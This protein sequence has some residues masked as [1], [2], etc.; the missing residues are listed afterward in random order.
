MLIVVKCKIA[1]TH[2][3]PAQLTLTFLGQINIHKFMCM[4]LILSKFITKTN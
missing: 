2:T 4:K 3:T 1:D